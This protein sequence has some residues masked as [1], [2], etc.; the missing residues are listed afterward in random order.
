M[1]G[2]A[3]FAVTMVVAFA[4]MVI[5][6]NT[7]QTGENEQL[8]KYYQDYITKCISKNQS[9][10]TLQTSKSENLRN[11]GNL[12]KQKIIFL[13]NNQNTLVN[14][15]IKNKVGTKPYKI[16]YFLNKKFHETKR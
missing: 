13:T 1:N 4:L 14:E 16:D 2:K 6:P 9:K 5:L 7:G 11:S 10:A 15:M 8:K 3:L 12:S